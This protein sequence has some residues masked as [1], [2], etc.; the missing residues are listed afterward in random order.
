MSVEYRVEMIRSR[1]VARAALR[2]IHTF[3]FIVSANDQSGR[4][5]EQIYRGLKLSSR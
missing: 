4:R 1:G 2:C 5:Q 3:T